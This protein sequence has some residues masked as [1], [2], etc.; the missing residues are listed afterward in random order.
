[1]ARFRPLGH[2]IEPIRE[3]EQFLSGFRDPGLSR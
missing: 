2:P 1:M 3:L